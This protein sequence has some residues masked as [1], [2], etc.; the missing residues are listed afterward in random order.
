MSLNQFTNLTMKPWMKIACGEMNCGTMVASD[1]QE[2]NIGTD[3]DFTNQ[4]DT[5]SNPVIGKTKIYTKNDS[6]LY[7]LDSSGVEKLV[8]DDSGDITDLEIK[9]QN[10]DL[11]NTVPG[12]TI[13]NGEFQTD[14]AIISGIDM[15]N[16]K[17]TNMSDPTLNQDSATKIYV[18]TEIT[19]ATPDLTNLNTKTQ[20]ID[21]STTLN[22]T[23][24]NGKF[25]T[26]TFA[27]NSVN[28]NLGLNSGIPGTFNGAIDIGENSGNGSLTNDSH[29]CIGK[30]SGE[31]LTGNNCI[32]ISSEGVANS[33]GS[34]D[35]KLTTGSLN[36]MSTTLS[37][38]CINIGTSNHSSLTTGQ[39]N[40][41]IGNQCNTGVT[42]GNGNICFGNNCGASTNLSN[43]LSFGNQCTPTI[44]NEIVIGGST[45]LLTQYTH[46]RPTENNIVDFGTPVYSWKDM[47]LS[48]NASSNNVIL[49]GS[50][51]GNVTLS[52]S[53]VTTN[54]NITLPSTV[55]ASLNARLTT[56]NI[57][58]QL[59]WEK[60]IYCQYRRTIATQIIPSGVNT[61]IEWDTEITN[62]S[63]MVNVDV[64]KSAFTLTQEGIYTFTCDV[65]SN[66]TTVLFT[67]WVQKSNSNK[68]LGTNTSLYTQNVNGTIFIEA[69]SIMRVYV[70]QDSGVD[71]TLISGTGAGAKV[72]TITRI[73]G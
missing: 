18:D 41:S 6:L 14:T 43:T 26:D 42:T 48:G 12:V 73:S 50:T 55:E 52:P 23:V 60:R 69:G 47:Y 21:L 8:G 72:F 66:S 51:S 5:P 65:E 29:I 56:S 58:G 28:I 68:Y 39:I 53:P 46:F 7:S 36:E 64:T 22:N 16:N 4:V 2:M 57:S 32:S 61:A 17:I 45:P 1:V 13:H 38:G 20:N 54:Y 27:V 59:S 34:R 9:T 67:S 44:S 31:T 35:I 11:I 40:Y 24:H 25:E 49:N 63:G 3:V 15:N 71:Q 10:I 30:G 70:R 62:D 37:N 33:C 19:N